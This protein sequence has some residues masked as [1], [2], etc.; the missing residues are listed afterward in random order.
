MTYRNYLLAYV[1]ISF[2]AIWNSA[3]YAQRFEDQMAKLMRQVLPPE[4]ECR[5]G[6]PMG[7]SPICNYSIKAEGES[8]EIK[9]YA[10]ENMANLT[11][12]NVWVD[13]KTFPVSRDGSLKVQALMHNFLEKFAFSKE[14]VLNC[15]KDFVRTKNAKV[16]NRNWIM[17]CR[18]ETPLDK[19]STVKINL[20]P[21]NRF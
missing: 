3:S 11:A 9:L 7:N 15:F 5:W 19:P 2:T 20:V 16:E 1:V 4:A 13:V 18:I 12:N 21:S 14:Q 6:G 17:I 8:H 10:G